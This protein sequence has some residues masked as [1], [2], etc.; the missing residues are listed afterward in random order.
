MVRV[1]RVGSERAINKM[2]G[3]LAKFPIARNL[4][5]RR[6]MPLSEGQ[7]RHSRILATLSQNSSDMWGARFLQSV[8]QLMNSL[9]R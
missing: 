1:P 9:Q 3:F 2:R 7:E 5:P 8:E 6:W 4:S